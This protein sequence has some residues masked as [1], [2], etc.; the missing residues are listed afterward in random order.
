[1]LKKFSTPGTLGIWLKR[2]SNEG[3]W[4]SASG[5][6][7]VYPAV[8][9]K[10]SS[11]NVCEEETTS[12]F[13]STFSVN[14]VSVYRW[15]FGDGK[16]SGIQNPTRKY[17]SPGTYNTS[18]QVTTLPGCNYFA[19]GSNIVHPKP[20]AGF[21][22]DPDAGTILN[23]NISF[24]DA[25]KGADSLW[26]LISTGYSTSSRNFTRAFPDSGSFSIKQWVRTRFGCMDSFNK[27]IYINFMYTLHV[28]TAFTPNS[29]GLNEGFSPQGMGIKWY[30][31]KV[32][33]RW[34]Q[35]LYE[36][37]QSRPWDGTYNG[38]LLPEGVYVV[39]IELRDFKLK[40][41]YYKGSVQ[42]LHP[43]NK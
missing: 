16:N 15:T 26:Y 13:D 33:N 22:T 32:Y 25:S 37:D 10:Y 14:P 39:L 21:I 20:K 1:V 36:T 28:P 3:C 8:K 31:M 30:G 2:R 40:R 7:V 17:N 23:P 19:K 27:D 5:S 4:D 34:G 29:D 35:K 41:H 12:F 43:Y 6:T 9:V 42:L 18:L 38:Q 24:T 11:T